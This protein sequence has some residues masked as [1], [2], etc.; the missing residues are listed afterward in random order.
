MGTLQASRIISLLVA[1]CA[2]LVLAFSPVQASAETRSLKLYFLHTGERAEITFKKNGKYIDSGLKKINRFLRDWR[3]N[4]PTKMD[5][6]LLDLIWEVYK[7]SGARKPIHV[8]SAYR[9]PATNSLLR[10]R[11]RGVA[12]KS[13]HTLG[14]AM[15]FFLP[16]VKLSKL[17]AIG[18]RKGIGGVGYYPKSGS[19]FVHM[20]T[21][22][23]RHWPRMSRKQLVK[24]FPRG[25]TLHVPSDGKPLPGYNQAKAEYERKVKGQGKIVIA[26]AEEIKKKPGFFA[27]LLGSRDDDEDAGAN[28]T[29][30]PRPVTT[31][32]NAPTPAAA[33]T[34]FEIANIPVPLAAPRAERQNVVVAEIEQPTIENAQPI[35]S[36]NDEQPTE[37]AFAIP[38][39]SQRPQ[40]EG[41]G[42]VLALNDPN[43]ENQPET[44][45]D[46][47]PETPEATNVAALLPEEPAPRVVALS[48]TE[49]EDLRNR[50][51]TPKET[52]TL[53]TQVA[54]VDAETLAASQAASLLSASENTSL[55]A[56]PVARPTIQH[57]NN[58]LEQIKATEPQGAIQKQLAATG[59]SQTEIELNNEALK[60]T[61][62]TALLP[63]D[64]LANKALPLKA[65]RNIKTVDDLPKIAAL[66]ASPSS[67][68]S[69]DP[70][71]GGEFKTG[72]IAVPAFKPGIEIAALDTPVQTTERV[73]EIRPSSLEAFSLNDN[74][75]SLTGKWAL[76]SYAS[77]AQIGDI[78]LPA[79]GRNAIRQV[80]DTVL[81]M[82][83]NSKNKYQYTDHFAGSSVEFLEFSRFN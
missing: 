37:I 62:V 8:I 3:R 12:K 32:T 30:A 64:E 24:V 81:T 54:A 19:P 66:K 53:G 48:A 15:D 50:L 23:V 71:D 79:Y 36:P 14:K 70:I 75:A 58:Q 10:K 9:S 80:P 69:L 4:E 20:D 6:R 33:P 11:G 63:I 1:F 25:K 47:Q 46:I 67:S 60:P 65:P 40:I 5:P 78:R 61:L 22:R 41:A 82:G 45:I 27:K 68:L 26:K 77:I 28:S 17:R 13:Q 16:D 42:T 21:G 2:F 38:V 43:V 34:S 51:S 29:P 59:T 39:P 83:F 31:V 55:I 56:T 74:N 72:E 52:R 35:D 44:E 49:I 18:L 57:A 76:A 7:E 73:L